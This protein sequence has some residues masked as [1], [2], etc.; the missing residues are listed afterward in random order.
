MEFFRN[1]EIKRELLASIGCTVI[2]GILLY[3][4]Y[5]AKG[6]AAALAIG[7]SI[8]SVHFAENYRRYL[9]IQKMGWQIDQLLHGNDISRLEDCKEG[10]LSVLSMQINKMVCRLKE[11]SEILIKEK[12]FLA[13]SLT[14]ISH[15]IK[16][17]LTS[18]G[19]ILSFLKEE[20]LTAER[21]YELVQELTKLTD[22]IDWLIYA[23]LKMSKLDA[24]AVSLKKETISVRDCIQN[25]YDSIAVSL[26]IRGIE[27]EQK[28]EPQAFITG[29]GDWWT[30]AIAN[31]LKNC[32]EHT[33]AGGKIS[34]FSKENTLYTLICIEDSGTGIAEEDLPHIFER[35]YRG[36]NTDSQSVGIGLALSHKIITS[37]NGTITAANRKDSTGAVFEIRCYKST[38]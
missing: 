36:K 37:Q 26:D 19:L 12:G 38:V 24:G 10:D 11:Q 28:I 27:F 1:P 8:T 29:D 2:F 20:N 9:L 30:E 21:R 15:Q 13:D 16:T 3:L 22:R 23:L 34:V 6:A 35:F 4:P 7:I 5:G 31:I 33:P 14:D 25:A 32:M 18:I 17:P